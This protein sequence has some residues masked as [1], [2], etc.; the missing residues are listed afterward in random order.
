MNWK[1][2]GRIFVPPEIDEYCLTHAANPLVMQIDK[3]IFRIFYSGRNKDNK[4][5]IAFFDFDMENMEVI[6]IADKSVVTFGGDD[7]FYS[8]GISIGTIYSVDNN[9]YVLFMGWQIRGNSHWRGDIGR[10]RFLDSETLVLDPDAAYMTINDEDPVS[11]SYP[12]VLKDDDVYKMW[13]GSTDTWDAGNGE[14]VHTIK[15][16]T[17]CDG[18]NW[19]RHGV[20]V[21]YEIGVAQ[22]FSRPT[23]FKDN[24]GYKM[25]FS[26]R[27]GDGTK[28]RIGHAFSEDGVH[29][30]RRPSGID[31]SEDGWDSDMICYPDIFE[32]KNKKYMVYNGNGFG[33]SGVGLASLE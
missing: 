8:H 31:V 22:A 25:W 15:Y 2:L 14:M 9:N 6:K 1:K 28:Y 33:A 26:Y 30:E 5:S 21:P 32:Y 20:A 3:N 12:Y 18:S 24:D 17:S 27:P 23:V 16:A 13:Y 7:S 19:A 11:L 29:W 4:S 10:L